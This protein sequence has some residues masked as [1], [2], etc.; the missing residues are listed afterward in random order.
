MHKDV[1][2]LHG[3]LQLTHQ[4][5]IEKGKEVNIKKFDV[6]YYKRKFSLLF[7]NL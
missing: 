2:D 6:V 1:L 5:K 3:C 7:I 4:I